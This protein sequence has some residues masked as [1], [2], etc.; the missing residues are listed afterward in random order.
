MSPTPATA[1]ARLWHQTRVDYTEQAMALKGAAVAVFFTSVLLA[2]GPHRVT[3]ITKA[4]KQQY[5]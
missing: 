2:T 3:A 1:N 4:E 5:K